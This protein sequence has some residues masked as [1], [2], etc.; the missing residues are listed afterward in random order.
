MKVTKLLRRTTSLL[1]ALAMLFSF[2]AGAYSEGAGS[3][4]KEVLEIPEGFVWR[5]LSVELAPFEE[6]C[7]QTELRR[8]LI[9]RHMK[10]LK[11]R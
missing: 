10:R 9:V 1:L 4:S 8:A 7:A 6:D 2:P 5:T 11:H 3:N